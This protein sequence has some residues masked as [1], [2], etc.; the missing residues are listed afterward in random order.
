MTM[1]LVR[2]LSAKSALAALVLLVALWRLLA[3]V[4]TPG[5]N[6]AALFGH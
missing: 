6:W 4:P 5:I 2:T 1:T 3:F